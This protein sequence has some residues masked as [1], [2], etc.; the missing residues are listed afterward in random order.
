MLPDK[1]G[2]II[3]KE[4][5]ILL[6]SDEG[7]P[8]FWIP[9]GKIEKDEDHAACLARELQEELGVKMTSF[10]FYLTTEFLHEKANDMQT[11]H[12]YL[13]EVEG[14]PKVAKEITKLYWYAAEDFTAQEPKT[15]NVL[16][17]KLLPLLIA[18]GLL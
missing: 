13:V 6:V 15:T 18:E 10:S 3:I 9:G 7:T 5:K 12:Y 16:R 2:A 4:K 8:F 1:I 14:V 11:I 17:E